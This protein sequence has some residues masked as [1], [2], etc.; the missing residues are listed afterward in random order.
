MASTRGRPIALAPLRSA[1]RALADGATTTSRLSSVGSGIGSA[2]GFASGGD[3]ENGTAGEARRTRR[4]HG[5]RV[6]PEVE[7]MQ[8]PGG[9]A[10][11]AGAPRSRPP[12][13][14]AIASR[15]YEAALGLQSTGGDFE[16]SPTH[17][18]CPNAMQ[19]ARR[20]HVVCRLQACDT[21]AGGIHDMCTCVHVRVCPRA[22]RYQ[23]VRV[24]ANVCVRRGGGGW[25]CLIV[26]TDAFGSGSEDAGGPRSPTGLIRVPQSLEKSFPMSTYV[27]RD[28]EGFS[29]VR[30]PAASPGML[31]HG[32]L[33]SRLH[34]AVRFLALAAPP[35]R[36]FGVGCARGHKGLYRASP[37]VAPPSLTPSVLLPR[38][39]HRRVRCSEG[40]NTAPRGLG[41]SSTGRAGGAHHR[42]HP[43]LDSR[44]AAAGGKPPSGGVCARALTAL[45][46]GREGEGW[47]TPT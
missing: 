28:P 36:S 46:D 39:S 1:P 3:N 35:P 44:G 26:A 7:A 42:P 27:T 19:P 32:R 12:S 14:S 20:L 10:V 21:I 34:A 17:G 13:A 11:T 38:G 24:S 23:G 45:V 6:A 18:A 40:P 4:G 15:R 5:R 31:P 29:V 41:S 25:C 30:S 9:A 16:G 8:P 37:A 22:G 47:K 2:S 33:V 43:A